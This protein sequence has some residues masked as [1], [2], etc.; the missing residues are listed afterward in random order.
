MPPR[1]DRA[2]SFALIGVVYVLAVAAA[3]VTWRVVDAPP[4]WALLAGLAAATAVTF[5]ATLWLDNGS[6]FDAWW[7]VLPPFAALWLT[8][9]GGSDALSLRQLAVHVV[10]WCWA[11]RLTANWAVGWSGFDHE[12]W[13]YVDMKQRWPVPKWVVYAT[14]VEGFPTLVVWLGCLPLIPAL[15]S[16][17]A[18][19]G[20][21]DV[22]ATF[23]GLGAVALELAADEQMRAFAATKRPGEIMERGLWRHARHPN[24]LGE[25]GFWVSLWLFAVAAAPGAWWAIVGPAA[26]I[27]LFLGAS[28][29]LLDERSAA[30]R[31]DFAAHAARTRA[32][33][34]W[35]KRGA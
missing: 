9:Q 18:G 11:V 19:F 7:S 8:G 24:Y 5:V 27:A 33:L 31:P 16:G 34:P 26:M 17:D 2:G 14:A 28:I 25:I 13:R 30:R 4:A 20:A 3:W 15:T 21:L 23:V 22:L 1:P 29:P 12:D 10:V 32:L 6:V 35:P